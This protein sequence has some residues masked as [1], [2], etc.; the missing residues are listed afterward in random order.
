MERFTTIEMR[1]EVTQ[2]NEGLLVRM[3]GK[4]TGEYSEI[5]L[6]LGAQKV[7]RSAYE[8]NA[9]RKLNGKLERTWA[10]EF[11]REYVFPSRESLDKFYGMLTE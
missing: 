1:F 7:D 9:E 6:R 8:C 5:P 4:C 3:V 10:N 11:Y 2:V